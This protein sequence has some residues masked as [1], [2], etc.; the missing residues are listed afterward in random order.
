[1]SPPA[2]V[3]HLQ[4]CDQSASV[5]SSDGKHPMT[6]SPRS[7]EEAASKARFNRSTRKSEATARPK[8]S[9]MTQFRWGKQEV[10]NLR[11]LRLGNT[12]SEKESLM[13]FAFPGLRK[14]ARCPCGFK[15]AGGSL[16]PLQPLQLYSSIP[17]TLYN[18]L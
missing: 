1:M 14:T 5:Q 18:T 10:R 13:Q 11:H 6:P 16:Q 7:S 12:R 15:T 8:G 4:R 2:F 3:T 9:E 17:S